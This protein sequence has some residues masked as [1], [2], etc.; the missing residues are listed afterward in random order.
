MADSQQYFLEPSTEDAQNHPNLKHTI[1][2][3]NEIGETTVILRDNNVGKDDAVKSPSAD[4]HIVTPAYILIEIDPLNNW[5]VIKGQQY[6]LFISVFDAQN[7]KL[8]PSANLVAELDVQEGY[9]ETT[10]QTANGTW[11]TG[12]PV[13][14]G[15]ALVRATLIGVK[16]VHT[17]EILTLDKP[18]KAKAQLEI[19]APIDI[20]PPVSYFPWDPLNLAK[21]QVIYS[22]LGHETSASLT[23]ASGNKSVATVAQNGI[24]KTTGQLGQSKIVASMTRASHN[25]GKFDVYDL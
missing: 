2:A 12:T 6:N 10:S 17:G 23:W 18:L 5:H 7:R 4:L 14:A 9:F 19:F 20:D 1:V 21:S 22:I 25:R 15:S 8:F 3:G 11:I 16:D 13:Q 24:A